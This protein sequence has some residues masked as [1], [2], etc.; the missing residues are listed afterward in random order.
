MKLLLV[1]AEREAIKF[2]YS[3]MRKI[4]FFMLSVFI[5]LHLNCI[6]N[7]MS[8]V[9]TFRTYYVSPVGNDQN[10]GSF[11]RPWKTISRSLAVLEPGDTVQVL[12]GVY[13][14]MVI[15]Q[16]SGE[17]GKNIVFRAAPGQQVT[18]DLQ[19][20]SSGEMSYG[21]YLESVG[22]IK[23]DGFE[24]LNCNDNAIRTRYAENIV[25][26]GIKGHHC[27]E[28]GI[29]V[30]YSRNCVVENSEFYENGFGKPGMSGIS[31]WRSTGRN[32]VRYNI[33]HD[34]IEPS[35]YDGNGIIVDL[36]FDSPTVVHHN[37]CFDNMGAGLCIIE[38]SFVTASH[39]VLYHNG[40]GAPRQHNSLTGI[41]IERQGSG[42]RIGLYNNI[43]LDNYAG[44]L[45][46]EK[47]AVSPSH[48]YNNNCWFNSA[49]QKKI[50][51]Y[52]DEKLTLKEFQCKTSQARQSLNTDPRFIS[53]MTTDF[54]LRA[55]S[56]CIDSGKDIGFPY[57]GAA[58]DIGFFEYGA[59]ADSTGK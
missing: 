6:R 34:N 38:S 47:E 50:F 2:V 28:S 20:Q 25:I 41:T 58:P 43:C 29:E 36:C 54:H 8:S 9:E 21:F 17:A 35:E 51:F 30:M 23:I 11:N 12:E 4:L 37:I 19:Y 5:L 59:D 53:P 15:P 55:D 46:I 27:R 16:K 32:I 39:N 1:F 14:E 3:D 52:A 49:G 57:Y 48:R 24:I 45:N 31:V 22:F 44:E 42:N 18:L 56:P 10:P 40:Y 33:C 26:S 7:A 13:H